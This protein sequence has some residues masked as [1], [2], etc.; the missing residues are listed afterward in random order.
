MILR[1]SRGVDGFEGQFAELKYLLFI[2]AVSWS[3]ILET[4]GLYEFLPI[5]TKLLA[6]ESFRKRHNISASIESFFGDVDRFA[7]EHPI[8]SRMVR[9]RVGINNVANIVVFPDMLQG[10]DTT[11]SVYQDRFFIRYED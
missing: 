6:H 2:V 1:V 11:T 4:D 3:A 8:A 5:T 10:F 7:V 9:M